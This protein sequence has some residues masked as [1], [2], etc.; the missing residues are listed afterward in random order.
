MFSETNSESE[1]VISGSVKDGL[2]IRKAFLI[3]LQMMT[4]DVSRWNIKFVLLSITVSG[5]LNSEGGPSRP[6]IVF[7]LGDD[8]VSRYLMVK[9]L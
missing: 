9:M 6:H 8:V 5:V 3:F 7:I 4:T 2:N 1:V